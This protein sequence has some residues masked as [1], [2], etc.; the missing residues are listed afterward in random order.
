MLKD[1]IVEVKL[2][3]IRNFQHF[4]KYIDTQII[5]EKIVSEFKILCQDRNWKIRYEILKSTPHFLVKD[6]APLLEDFIYFNDLLKEDHIYCIRERISENL[7]ECYSI[8][9]GGKL[10]DVVRSLLD[11]WSQ[12][13]NYIF[14][15]SSLQL[16]KSF[17]GILNPNLFEKLLY[18]IVGRLKSDKVGKIDIGGQRQTQRLETGA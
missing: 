16:M 14:R 18:D 3:S 10:D 8:G 15:V 11:H 6:S 5:K 2:S 17:I 7:V 4:Y 1:A 12:S 9:Q 13:N